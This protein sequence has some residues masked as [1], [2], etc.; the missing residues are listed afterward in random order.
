[1]ELALLIGFNHTR[2]RNEGK[3]GLKQSISL[4]IRIINVGLRENLFW[5][6]F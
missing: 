5:K 3:S 4:F 1:M 2:N 6:G